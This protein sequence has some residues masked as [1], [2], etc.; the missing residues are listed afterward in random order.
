MTHRAHA[1]RGRSP[2]GIE[3]PLQGLDDQPF[4]RQPSKLGSIDQADVV[5][6]RGQGGNALELGPRHLDRSLRDDAVADA[7]GHQSADQ[8]EALRGQD[9]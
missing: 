6:I 2:R 3:G 8:L 4:R 7:L 9:P 1:A 5:L